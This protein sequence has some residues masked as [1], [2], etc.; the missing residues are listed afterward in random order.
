MTRQLLSLK[1]RILR[2]ASHPAQRL[3]WEQMREV[4]TCFWD[5][6]ASNLSADFG[7]MLCLS[8]KGIDDNDIFTIRLDDAPDYDTD[9]A[10]RCNDSWLAEAARD[11]LE[12]YTVIV[13][14]YGDRYDLPFLNTRL[15]NYR[16]R[17]L[18]TGSRV[19]VDTWWHARHRL[20]LH[21]NRLDSL[22]HYLDTKTLKTGLDGNIWTSAVTGVRSS[23]DWVVKHNIH[24]VKALEEVTRVLATAQGLK[25]ST[26]K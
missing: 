8:I 23:M 17:L 15:L 10:V 1:E 9:P 20:K 3:T 11:K 22:I 12:E 21:N 4:G 13:H 16:R 6:E 18:D 26:W 2:T 19:F 25:Y 5:I 7:I 14:H 24:D